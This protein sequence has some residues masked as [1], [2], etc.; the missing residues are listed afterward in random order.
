[1][2]REVRRRGIGCGAGCLVA[3]QP[4]G[5]T[6]GQPCPPGIPPIALSPA[7]ACLVECLSR[8]WKAGLITTARLAFEL[9]WSAWRRRH[10]AR[11]RWHHY[12][13]RLATL[14]A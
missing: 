4:A 3:G 7:E 14:A 9:R 6:A 10:Q 13:T 2:P 5:V 1:V 8:G 11:A 12:S